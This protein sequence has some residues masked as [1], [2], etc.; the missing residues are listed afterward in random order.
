MPDLEGSFACSFGSVL[1]FASGFAAGR[2]LVISFLI[3]SARE[4]V[5]DSPVTHLF[6]FYGR[7][8]PFLLRPLRQ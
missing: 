6:I 3:T 4:T 2:D 1:F 8:A 7:L 5:S